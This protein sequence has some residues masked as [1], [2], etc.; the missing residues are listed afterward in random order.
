MRLYTI[1]DIIGAISSRYFD[2]GRDYQRQDRVLDVE[3]HEDGRLI[4]GITQGSRRRAYDQHVEI[5]VEPHGTEIVL[6]LS[7]RVQLQAR[8]CNPVGGPLSTRGTRP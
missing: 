2:R 7:D 3:F 5:H 6:Y 8:G 4:T 1:N